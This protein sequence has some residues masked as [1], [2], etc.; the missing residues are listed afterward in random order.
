MKK[1]LPWIKDN[2]ISLI[3]V[4]VALIAAPVM[5]FFASSWSGKIRKG[6]EGEVMQSVQQLE[7]LDVS[8]TIPPYLTGQTEVSVRASPNEATTDAVAALLAGI[9]TDSGKVRDEALA[10]N[11]KAKSLLISGASPQETLFPKPPDDSTRLRLLD[12]MIREWPAAH[13]RLLDQ[14]KIG[15]PPADQ[16]VLSSINAERA[17]EIARRTSG[18]DE[19]DL[20]TD[21]IALIKEILGSHRLDLYRRAAN[22]ITMYGSIKAFAAVQPWEAGKLLPIETAWEWQHIYWVHEEIVRALAKANEDPATGSWA[23]VI[24]APVKRLESIIVTKPGESADPARASS[25]GSSGGDEGGRSAGGGDPSAEIRA[26]YT[27]THTGRTAAPLAPNALYDIRFA[28]VVVI[29]SSR[30]LPRVIASFPATNFMTVVGVSIEEI[31]P[32]PLI[33][34]GYDFGGEHVVRATL[35]VET[36][37]FREWMKQHMPPTVRAALGIPEDARPGDVPADGQSQPGAPE[38]IPA[39]SSDPFDN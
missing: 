16:S 30:D 5:L 14:S 4:V 38:E 8:Y 6:V 32:L 24:R 29:V 31:D 21:D 26:D 7:G 1:F 39:G 2:L 27:L 11:S 36:V 9:I 3:A 17:K 35:K 25:S 15:E 18:G 19:K 10:F 33:A 12:Q 28:D 22:D 37:W 20:T 34:Q 23:P 13:Q